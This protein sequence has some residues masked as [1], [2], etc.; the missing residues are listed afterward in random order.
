MKYYVRYVDNMIL[1]GANKKELHKNVK[2]IE[3]YLETMELRLKE[4]WQVYKMAYMK[5]TKDGFKEVGRPLDFMGFVFRRNRITIRRSI[6]YRIMRTAR[7]IG[8]KEKP[9]IYDCRKML[10]YM[11]WITHTDTYNSYLTYVKPNINIK[12]MKRYVSKKDKE[13]SIAV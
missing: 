11:G 1:F 2:L 5:K 3:K 13:L 9:S 7:K 4:N 10:S 12:R 8:K 6:Y